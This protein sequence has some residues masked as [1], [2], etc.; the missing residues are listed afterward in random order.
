[1]SIGFA[2][3]L[4]RAKQMILAGLVAAIFIGGIFNI[5]LDPTK[6]SVAYA[7]DLQLDVK[8]AILIEV[9]T[10]QVLYQENADQ[11][12]PPAS[13][14]KMMTEYLVME[15]IASKKINW[16]DMVPVSKYAGDVI[17]SG[18]LIAEGEQLSVR[19]M[20]TAMAIYSSND[21]SV[22]LAE[23]VAGS[24]PSFSKMMNDA[25]QKFG[26][27]NSRFI[28][29]TGLSRED[30]GL[31]APPDIPGETIMSARDVALLAKQLLS[32]HPEILNYSKIP[33][34]K[35][36]LSDQAPMI[37]W[38]WMLDGNKDNINFKRYSYPGL[39]GLKTGHTSEAGYCFTGTANRNGMRL[40][41]VVMGATSEANR[42]IETRKLLDYGFNQFEMKQVV[43]EKH[44]YK[45][46][47]TVEVIDGV[48]LKQTV[49][50]KNELNILVEKGSKL[51]TLKPTFESVEELKRTAPIKK[52]S[53]LGKAIYDYGGQKYVVELVT[54][55][56]NEEAG[57]LRKFFRAIKDFF[58]G[59]FS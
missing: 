45:N 25:A 24:E 33:S 12:F 15:A 20:V 59:I 32:K 23:F 58:V 3:T 8:S 10:G 50:T 57:W 51:E 26:M 1:M 31:N 30:I 54:T 35:L 38:N 41:S 48:D 37:N 4:R 5:I 43:K 13:M 17:G 36:R 19:D 39:D 44:A 55:E 42:F 11:A 6:L 53:V 47:S 52:G 22:A 9:N 40:I 28:N 14:S 49:V 56:E 18:Q 29:A 7:A 46:F 2:V 34:K 27:K 16:D 21:A